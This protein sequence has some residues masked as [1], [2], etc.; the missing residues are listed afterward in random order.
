MAK[1]NT[2]NDEFR[3]E[4]VEE[5]GVIKTNK[6]TGWTTEIN[7]VSYNDRE[8]VV[9]I[10]SWD[11]DHEHMSKGITMTEKEALKLAEFI[12]DAF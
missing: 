2:N 10:R 11:E 7:L 6:K 8:P 4:I 12:N 5:I 1:K 9:D 3:F